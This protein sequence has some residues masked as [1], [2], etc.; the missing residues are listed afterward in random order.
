MDFLWK[1]EDGKS[2]APRV[3]SDAPAVQPTPRSS[4]LPEP[5][6]SFRGKSLSPSVTYYYCS[7]HQFLVNK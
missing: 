6:G 2:G 4:E 3:D 5:L 7:C 1:I